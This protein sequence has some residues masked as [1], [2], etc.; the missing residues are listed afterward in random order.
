M[1]TILFDAIIVNKLLSLVYLR[2]K[3]NLINKSN[4]LIYHKTGKYLKT[5]SVFTHTDGR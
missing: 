4:I 5:L 2:I 3:E 1:I